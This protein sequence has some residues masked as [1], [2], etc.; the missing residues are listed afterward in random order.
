MWIECTIQ[1]G[2]QLINFDT[3]SEVRESG[4]GTLLVFI[5]LADDGSDITLRADEPYEYFK[6]RLPVCNP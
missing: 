5:G 3:V 2:V 1:G 6:Q 4:P